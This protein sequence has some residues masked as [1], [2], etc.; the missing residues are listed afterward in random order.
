VTQA[1]NLTTFKVIHI[2]NK[3]M[4]GSFALVVGN[5]GNCTQWPV[6]CCPMVSHP[7]YTGKGH[8]V[9]ELHD[10]SIQNYFFM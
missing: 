7:V 4:K 2:K 3:F 10:K 6:N 8:K 1:N 9:R 5:S